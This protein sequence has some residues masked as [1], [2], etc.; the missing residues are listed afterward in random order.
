MR[1]LS[2][3][4]TS[5][6]L[7]CA[8]AGTEA[9]AAATATASVSVTVHIG[10]RTS[11]KVSSDT[12]RFD[13]P[14]GGGAAT[15]SISFSAGARVPSGADVVLT[16]EPLRDI[17]GTRGAGDVAGSIMFDGDG[18]GLLHG[19]LESERPAVVGR[20]RGS[21]LREGRLVF[22]IHADAPGPYALPVRFLLSTP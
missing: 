15:A 17:D 12:V 4:V 7:V 6:A 13:V 14:E 21:G 19:T 1:T 3:I 11:L 2:A 18:T 8:A 16:V 5:G 20:W 10:S 9:H 22:T